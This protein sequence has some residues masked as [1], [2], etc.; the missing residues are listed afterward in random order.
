MSH[1]IE[2][3][4]LTQVLDTVLK[5]QIKLL[6]SESDKLPI[7]TGISNIIQATLRNSPESL[8]Q[9]VD[10]LMNTLHPYLCVQP[11]EKDEIYQKNLNSFLKSFE[12]LAKHYT[13]RVIAFLQKKVEEKEAPKRIGTLICFKHLVMNNKKELA[14][15]KELIVGGLQKILNVEDLQ[16]NKKIKKEQI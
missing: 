14:D 10:T 6:Q 15:F 11:K 16:V 5:G 8:E 4:H 9:Y 12:A 3:E 1:I 7:S 2:V 13:D